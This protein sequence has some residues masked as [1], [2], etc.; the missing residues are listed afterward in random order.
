MTVDNHP[1]II[2]DLYFMSSSKVDI[3]IV[4]FWVTEL[5]FQFEVIKSLFS[6]N[7]VARLGIS[8]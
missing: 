2:L 7:I 6:E 1:V 5:G 4:F 8:S 3:T